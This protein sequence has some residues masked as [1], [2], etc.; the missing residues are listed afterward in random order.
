M[1]HRYSKRIV[2]DFHAQIYKTGLP[3]A[4]GRVRNM[5]RHGIFVEWEENNVSVNQLLDV[6]FVFPEAKQAGR[7]KCFVVRKEMNGF[8]LSLFDDAQPLYVPHTEFTATLKNTPAAQARTVLPQHRCW[9]GASG[10]GA[11]A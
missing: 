6:E 1:E 3:V 7:F 2:A 5:S 11:T 8:A 10:T 4:V 9:Q